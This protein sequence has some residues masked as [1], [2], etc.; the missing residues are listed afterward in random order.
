M[1]QAE[2]DLRKAESLG[3]FKDALKRFLDKYRPTP[4][5]EKD[6]S[7]ATE[8]LAVRAF[9]DGQWSLANMLLKTIDKKKKGS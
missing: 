5:T 1:A 7:N 4:M 2:T 9:K 6:Y 8:P 3:E